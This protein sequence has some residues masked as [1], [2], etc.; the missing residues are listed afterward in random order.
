MSGDS[1]SWSLPLAVVLAILGLIGVAPELVLSIATMAVG[2][3]LL[4][5]GAAIAGEYSR[6]L[7]ESPGETGARS[8]ASGVG[9]ESFA[10]LAGAVLGLLALLQVDPMQLLSVASIVLGAGLV[11]ASGAVTRLE[12]LSTQRGFEG[13]HRMR[14]TVT[15]SEVFVGLGAVALG[16]LALTRLQPTVLTL[17]AMLA[18][19]TATLFGGSSLATR[20]FGIFG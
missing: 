12:R 20:M 6:I 2:M 16:I 4:M 14:V 11:M 3:A 17:V 5:N 19:G 18:L 7:E 1:L 13:M 8:T 10:G 9:M 15:G